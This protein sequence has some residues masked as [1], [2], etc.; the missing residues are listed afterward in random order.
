[1]SN[2]GRHKSKPKKRLTIEIFNET[3]EK[4]VK[5]Y[6]DTIDIKN[7]WYI[8]YGKSRQT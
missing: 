5:Y 1:M 3:T 7:N 6:I 8:H 2:R 4:L